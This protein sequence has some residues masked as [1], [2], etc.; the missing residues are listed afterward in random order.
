[1]DAGNLDNHWVLGS[2]VVKTLHC[3]HYREALG[4]DLVSGHSLTPVRRVS[5]GGFLRV[6]P[7]ILQSLSHHSAK[8][9][10]RQSNQLPFAIIFRERKKG[11]LF[12]LLLFDRSLDREVK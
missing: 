12:S 5:L 10:S 9:L 8:S 11:V 7:V 1:M 3:H 6:L 4:S 2:E